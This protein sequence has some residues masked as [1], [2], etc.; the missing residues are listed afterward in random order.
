MK[1]VAV[2]LLLFSAV[3]GSELSLKDTTKGKSTE[4]NVTESER[5]NIETVGIV[6]RQVQ[7]DRDQNGGFED[8]RILKVCKLAFFDGANYRFL[9]GLD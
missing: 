2:C 4:V 3:F 1:S 7:V 8:A 9:E 5:E 6:V